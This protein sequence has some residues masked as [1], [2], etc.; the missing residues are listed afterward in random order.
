MALLRDIAV[1]N[2][3]PQPK[4]YTL[5]DGNSLYLNVAPNGSKNWY[6]RFYYGKKQKKCTLGSYPLVSIKEARELRDNGKK[7]LLS[8]I[9]PTKKNVRIQEDA[10]PHSCQVKDYI[11]K[12]KKIKFEKLGQE[13]LQNRKSTAKQIERYFNN[14]IIP[15]IG[16]LWLNQVDRIHIITI[17]KKVE[18]RGALT[19]RKKLCSW[20][21]EMFKYA[22]SEGLID[23]NPADL[24]LEV[25]FHEPLPAENNPYLTMDELPR[26]W[27]DFQKVNANIQNKLG[28]RLLFLTGVRP[29][30]LRKAT[31]DQF[32][33][34]NAIWR[35]PPENVKQL[36]LRIAKREA[37]LAF[38]SRR[39]N[40]TI[41]R[42]N[43]IPPYLVPLSRQAVE[44]IKQLQ[45]MYYPGQKFLLGSRS[46]PAKS[47]SENTL[48]KILIRM[49]Y[50][51]RLT[52]HGIRATISTAL[53]E[54]RYDKD[55][56][57][58][59]LSHSDKTDKIRGIYNHANY[60]EGRQQMM[61]DWADRL[62]AWEREGINQ[63][64]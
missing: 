1:R 28:I 41:S 21:H 18:Q 17:L 16:S 3:K 10:H 13:T 7:L 35:V 44:V 56:I 60:I 24:E 38:S 19:V 51:D 33:L 31:L 62:E 45:R 52:S 57:E 9:C 61:Q 64:G 59:Q 23:S 27:A 47:I 63:Y 34:D 58:A 54:L 46:E 14:E 48:N 40:K 8:G 42:N 2:A 29:G 49:G 4:S 26:F 43:K 55:Y 22:K 6:F 25:L 53:N 12:W 30:E 50:K 5:T 11:E 36:K 37:K 20:L 32:D 15:A 39:K